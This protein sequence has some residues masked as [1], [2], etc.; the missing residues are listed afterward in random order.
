M[1][2]GTADKMLRQPRRRMDG[3]VLA[4]RRDAVTWLVLA[5]DHLIHQLADLPEL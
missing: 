1:R 4:L 5:P 3:L 2:D